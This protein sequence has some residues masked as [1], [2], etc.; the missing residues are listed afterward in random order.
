MVFRAKVRSI[1]N[2]HSKS[3]ETYAYSFLRSAGRLCFRLIFANYEIPRLE[4]AKLDGSIIDHN[5]I[6]TARDR[7][8]R[9]VYTIHDNCTT[10]RAQKSSGLADTIATGKSI[11]TQRSNHSTFFPTRQIVRSSARGYLEQCAKSGYCIMSG[12]SNI[13][14]SFTTSRRR[15]RLVWV[16]QF[17]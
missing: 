7:E 11:L 10:D 4:V 8:L 17:C 14:Y 12:L 2:T 6:N 16:L 5:E 1:G 3:Q 9:S 15:N 13:L